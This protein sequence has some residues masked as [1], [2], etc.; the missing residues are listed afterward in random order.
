MDAG[1]FVDAH[2]RRFGAGGVGLDHG[3]GDDGDAEVGEQARGEG[4]GGGGFADDAGQLGVAQN[5]SDD[6]GVGGA[7]AGLEEG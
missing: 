6:F 7:V 5:S 1:A 4:L 2:E 3:H